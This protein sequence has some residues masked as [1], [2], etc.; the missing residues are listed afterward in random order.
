MQRR[1]LSGLVVVFLLLGRASA[2]PTKSQTL[3]EQY[4][5]LN[6]PRNL[7]TK[8]VGG[9]PPRFVDQQI[10]ILRQLSARRTGEAA[11]L[12]VKIVDEYLKRIHDLGGA[13]FRVSVL[14]SMQIALTHLM[15]AHAGSKIV[16]ERMETFAKSPVISEYARGRVIGLIVKK[17]LEEIK[18]DDD[19]DGTKRGRLLMDALMGDVTMSQLLHAPAR[20]RSLATQ[21]VPL[22]SGDPMKVRTALAPAATNPQRRYAADYAFL[23]AVATRQ[24]KEKKTLDDDT[25]QTMLDVAGKWVGEYRPRV[26]REKYPSDL[27]GMTVRALGGYPGNKALAAFLKENRISVTKYVE[28]KKIDVYRRPEPRGRKPAKPD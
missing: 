28:P 25:K 5:K 15:A 16:F 10:N 3:Y 20:L 4:E 27:L 11:P 6:S 21:A 19:V 23:L 2:A 1:S 26:V 14:Q 13:K 9:R 12:V 22:G 7:S 24:V 8:F 17:R 18:P